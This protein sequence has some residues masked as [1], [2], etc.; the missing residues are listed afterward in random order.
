[1]AWYPIGQGDEEVWIEN[2]EERENDPDIKIETEEEIE[3]ET[4]KENE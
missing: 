2:K 1:M 4:K 3:N